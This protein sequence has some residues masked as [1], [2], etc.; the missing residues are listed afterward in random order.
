[1]EKD[2][3][4]NMSVLSKLTMTELIETAKKLKLDGVAGL[5]KQEREGHITIE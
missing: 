4:M 3:S 2:K 5:R 1:M